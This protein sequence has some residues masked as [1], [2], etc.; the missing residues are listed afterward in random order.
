MNP[1]PRLVCLA[2]VPTMLIA[3][4]APQK[5]KPDE[6]LKS[7]TAIIDKTADPRIRERVARR[8]GSGK[9]CF[10]LASAPTSTYAF[11]EIVP[12]FGPDDSETGTITATATLTLPSGE[13]VWSR[14][15]RVV[16]RGDV[17]SALVNRLLDRLATDAG[18]KTRTKAN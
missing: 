8:I 11:F 5:D 18:C 17:F 15:E 2:I 16:P 1:C 7:V 14:A 6:R 9:T 13:R 4:G 10:T 12:Y 3:A